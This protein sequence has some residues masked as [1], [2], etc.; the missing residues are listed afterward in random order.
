MT[1]FQDVSWKGFVELYHVSQNFKIHSAICRLSLMKVAGISKQASNLILVFP[2][3]QKGSYVNYSWLGKISL[4]MF[5]IKSTNHTSQNNPIMIFP[6][7]STQIP[8]GYGGKT[9]PQLALTPVIKLLLIS[10]S[11]KF[12]IILFLLPSRIR[13][14]LQP[15][16]FKS[17]WFFLFSNIPRR[18]QNSKS[19]TPKWVLCQKF[20]LKSV[21]CNLEI[22]P[23]R[24]NALNDG[25]FARRVCTR[26][27]ALDG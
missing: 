7:F 23:R 4:E 17:T 9:H 1:T 10:F 3:P 15:I 5:K 2:G 25:Y 8:D 27:I 14:P 16:Y 13:Y 11:S 19:P 24:N 26:W 18:T 20:I 22:F 6:P 21:T 12:S